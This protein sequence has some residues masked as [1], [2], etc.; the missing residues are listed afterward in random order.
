[1]T[2]RPSYL[3][4]CLWKASKIQ[5]YTLRYHVLMMAI[6]QVVLL[7]VIRLGKEA[8]ALNLPPY[9]HLVTTLRMLEV[10]PPFLHTPSRCAQILSLPFPLCSETNGRLR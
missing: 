5:I 1:M 8:E 2:L 4:F 6:L 9:L 10:I 7:W 3:M